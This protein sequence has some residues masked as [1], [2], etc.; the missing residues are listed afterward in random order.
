MFPHSETVKRAQSRD[1]IN[2]VQK[3][4]LM[5]ASVHWFE[6]E[7]SHHKRQ[8]IATFAAMDQSASRDIG[9]MSSDI[10]LQ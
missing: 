5:T 3:A 4:A 2:I 7:I 10:Y 8:L 1:N 6:N 9:Y